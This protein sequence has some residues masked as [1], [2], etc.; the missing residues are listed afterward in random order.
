LHEQQRA[1]DAERDRDRAPRGGTFTILDGEG[2]QRDRAHRARD[3]R[4]VGDRLPR[5][6]AEHRCGPDDEEREPRDTPTDEP[7]EHPP[8]QR[9]PRDRTRDER[10]ADRE[11]H[12]PGVDHLAGVAAIVGDAGGRHAGGHQP[13]HQHRLAA[14]AFDVFRV[15]VRRAVPLRMHEVVVL[16]HRARDLAVVRLPRIE[17]RVAPDA[18]NEQCGGE[19]DDD[20]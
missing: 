2:E 16:Q 4:H 5:D 11:H 3:H 20:R 13:E 6:Q 8:Q 18:G 7:R 14:K 15:A 19:R 10:E 1:G 17:Q 12:A 9:E